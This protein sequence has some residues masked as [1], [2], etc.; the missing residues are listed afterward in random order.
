RQPATHVL[1]DEVHERDHHLDDQQRD[2][3]QRQEAV[4]L[5]PAEREKERRVEQI[6][7]AV[8]AQLVLLRGAPSEALG[9]LVV[10]ERVERAHEN[11]QRDQ[12]PEDES[13]HVPASR[14]TAVWR[15]SAPKRGWTRSSVK[16]NQPSDS[17]PC[18]T[19]SAPGE[20]Q[21]GRGKRRPNSWTKYP[22]L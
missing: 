2:H 21:R 9:Q 6:A 8:Q 11:L 18:A 4:R 10:I 16:L 17:S 15:I 13:G 7:D 19:V 20:S 3:Q 14:N 5:A 12:R 22:A 1:L